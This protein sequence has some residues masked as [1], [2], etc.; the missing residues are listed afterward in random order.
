MS[1]WKVERHPAARLWVWRDKV[2]LT[3]LQV[4][5]FRWARAKLWLFRRLFGGD[6]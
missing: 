5:S 3:D 1:G 4:A 2:L 6:G